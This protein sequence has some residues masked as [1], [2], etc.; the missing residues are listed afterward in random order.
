M[1]REK[2]ELYVSGLLTEDQETEPETYGAL[3]VTDTGFETRARTGKLT[4]R[5]SA[6]WDEVREGLA[7]LRRKGA[8]DGHGAE[9]AE[10]E[11][12][13]QS[14]L[15]YGDQSAGVGPN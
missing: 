13:A 15:E 14:E 5:A 7:R 9:R 4:F 8:D 3:V 2:R 12:G 11:V 1:L 10:S 6:T